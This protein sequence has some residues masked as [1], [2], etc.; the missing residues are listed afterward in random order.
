[1]NMFCTCEHDLFIVLCMTTE[2]ALGIAQAILSSYLKTYSEQPADAA[3]YFSK[4]GT[5]YWDDQQFKGKLEIYE[6][7]K[8]QKILFQT[9]TVDV[10]LVQIIPQIS[11]VCASG[12]AFFIGQDNISK[13][14]STTLYIKTIHNNSDAIIL[15]QYIRF[16]T[17]QNQKD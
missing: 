3:N 4:Q 17:Q 13:P 8:T 16:V 14:F 10:Q 11:M 1:M 5:L 15:M 6:F 12:I 2:V 9:S 7:L